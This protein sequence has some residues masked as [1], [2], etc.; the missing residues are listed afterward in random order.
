VCLESRQSQWAFLILQRG[1]L[2]EAHQES[3]R[4][5]CGTPLTPPSRARFAAF[6]FEHHAARNSFLLYK[7]ANLVASNSGENFVALEN[8]LHVGEIK[9]ADLPEIF[10]ARSAMWSH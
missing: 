6:E 2:E 1:L 5:Q 8:A 9:S 4:L 7:I 10:G 3:C